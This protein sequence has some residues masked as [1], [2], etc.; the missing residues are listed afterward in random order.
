MPLLILLFNFTLA[1][2][3]IICILIISLRTF[4]PRGHVR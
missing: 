1:Y 2:Q 3:C 4:A